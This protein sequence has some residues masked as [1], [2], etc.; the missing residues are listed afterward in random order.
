M[1]VNCK[2]DKLDTL[3]AYVGILFS[4]MKEWTYDTCC[5]MDSSLKHVKWKK[6]KKTDPK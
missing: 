4:R 3:Y 6:K 5:N 1:S 2:V